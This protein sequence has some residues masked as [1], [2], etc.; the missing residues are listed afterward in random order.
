MTIDNSRVRIL[1]AT[2]ACMALAFVGCASDNN[3]ESDIDSTAAAVGDAGVITVEDVWS[4]RPAPGQTS[5]AVYAT[6]ANNTSVD[7]VL[8]SV[9]TAVSDRAELH[10]TVIDSGGIARMQA[11][12]DGFVIAAGEALIFQPSGAHIML[13]DIEE[14]DFDNSIELALLFDNGTEVVVSATLLSVGETINDSDQDSD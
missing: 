11:Q 5:A 1:I 2:L 12:T 14:A 13:R 7:R 10:E 4:R 6:V 8:V 3:P 9:T